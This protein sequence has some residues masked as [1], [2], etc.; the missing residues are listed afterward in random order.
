[1]SHTLQ[2]TGSHCARACMPPMLRH[3]PRLALGESNDFCGWMIESCKHFNLFGFRMQ[4]DGVTT[5]VSRQGWRQRRR[6]CPQS[7]ASSTC[8]HDRYRDAN[9]DQGRLPRGPAPRSGTR[10][11]VHT[12]SMQNT[13]HAYCLASSGGACMYT[14]KL[15]PCTHCMAH[16]LHIRLVKICVRGCPAVDSFAQ[17]RVIRL[18]GRSHAVIVY[19]WRM[20]DGA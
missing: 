14:A 17:S 15:P 12:V 6:S 13:G 10:L 11:C 1:M 7:R 4:H 3:Y 18:S 20:I 5:K 2:S 16:C 8:C 9:V 19:A